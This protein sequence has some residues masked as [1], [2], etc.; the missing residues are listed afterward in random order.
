MTP[1]GSGD[2]DYISRLH[3]TVQSAIL[4]GEP[5]DIV[6]WLQEQIITCSA[7]GNVQNLSETLKY[8]RKFRLNIGWS[9]A[10]GETAIIRAWKCGHPEIVK[11]IYVYAVSVL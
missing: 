8:K 4:F 9:N 7:S 3:Y 10:S 6:H 11:V 2:H 5:P 1:E